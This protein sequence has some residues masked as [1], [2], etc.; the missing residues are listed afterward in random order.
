MDEKLNLADYA[1]INS[2][3]HDILNRQC[4][5]LYARITAEI[6]IQEGNGRE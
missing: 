3:D 2:H 5:R 6:A 4:E 1:I